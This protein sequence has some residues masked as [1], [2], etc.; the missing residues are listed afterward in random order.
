MSLILIFILL[1]V[2][3]LCTHAHK[4]R[5]RHKNLHFCVPVYTRHSCLLFQHLTCT[6]ACGVCF[7][8]KRKPSFQYEEDE[9]YY[10]SRCN[11]E[12]MCICLCLQSSDPSITATFMHVWRWSNVQHSPFPLSLR[13]ILFSHGSFC[14]MP[15]ASCLLCLCVFFVFGSSQQISEEAS[16]VCLQ[17]RFLGLLFFFLFLHCPSLVHVALRLLEFLNSKYGTRTSGM[18]NPLNSFWA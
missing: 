5:H 11:W 1:S 7:F 18:K 2:W 17:P 10:S 8:L 14:G 16:G 15:H 13:W 12:S 6:G 4:R 9:T 3:C